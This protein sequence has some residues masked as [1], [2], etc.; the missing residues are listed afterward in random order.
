MQ[1]SKKLFCLIFVTFLINSNDIEEII[2]T[3][4]LLKDNENNFSPVQV[5]DENDFK[6]FN[7]TN[8][9]EISKYLNVSA[10]SRF[11][12]NALE[13]VDQGMS[14]ITLRGLDSSATL[15]LLNSKRHT[16]S[17]TP[18]NNGNGYIDA[19]IVPEIAIEKI[20]ILKEGATSIYGSDAI[21]GVINF[22]TFKDFEGLRIKVGEQTTTNYDQDDNSFG[23][24]YGTKILN[25]NLVIGFNVLERSPLSASEID[26]IAELGLSGLGK[27]FK[28]FGPDTVSSSL[29]AGVYP[30]ASQFVPDPNCEENGGVLD[31]SFCRFLYG[32]RFNIV[33]DESHQKIYLNFSKETESFKHN[34]HFISSKVDV[35][36]NPQ[37]PSYPALPFLSRN[38]EPGDGG[39]PFNVPVVWYGRPLGSEFKSPF[40]PKEIEQFNL[41]YS[42]SFLINQKTSAEISITKSEHSNEHFRPDIIDSRFLAAIKGNGGPDGNQTWNIF[43]SSQNPQSLID[44]VR[45]AEISSKLADLISIDGIFNTKIEGFNLAY[46]F[47]LNR[48][49]LD[50]FYDEI[51]RAEF[52]KDG[53]LIK[54]AD[55]FFLG[56]GKN[57]SKSRKSNALFAELEKDINEN[58]D[59]SL[60]ARF[61]SMKNESSF[62]PKVSLKYLV[63]DS[64]TIRFSKGTAFSAPSMAQMFS[65]EINLGSVRDIND[66]VF[67]RQASTGNPNLKPANST[68][69]NIGLIFQKNNL[70][71]SLDLWEI[72]YKDRVEVES[73]QAILSSNP[74]GP[75]VTRNEFGDLIGV[76][77]TYFN[78]DNTLVKGMDIQIQY[79][80]DL[81]K[82]NLSIDIMGTYLSDFKTPSL[83]NSNE[84]INRVGRFNFDN[85][86][87]SLPKKRIN[88]FI[89]WNF[90]DYSLSLNSRYLDGYVNERAVTGLG[91]TYGYNNQ[92][93]SFFVHDASFEKIIYM[94]KGDLNFRFYLSNIL[95]KSAPRL[96]DAPDFS[97]DTRLHDPRGRI[98]GLNIEY[99]Y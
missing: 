12:S 1:L 90:K 81:R 14:S 96:Y 27:T 21:A 57:L 78:E 30:K 15:L 51:S 44:Y 53:K 99:N 86:T 35:N 10:G 79:L 20:E 88:S 98:L 7:I 32:E 68:N 45:G 16:F 80:I 13:G 66:S 40:S 43:D 2:V 95:D 55:L 87:F 69:S 47:Q 67:V 41:N 63:S 71:L 23:L 61:E 59:I 31:G 91:L 25:G 94:S 93:K 92:V 65:S 73:A 18:S 54:T 37:S 64:L 3:G 11:Q 26:G 46:G 17:G 62:D 52:D 6:N 39:S 74:N 29:Y 97:F 82:G 19:N 58:L 75:S 38:I 42:L 89:S 72:K 33:N 22:F 77:T 84:M 9:G 83:T 60:A 8:I 34:L 28:V 70:R 48:E 76:T 50:I 56:G 4:T 85:H 36:D 49:N 24:L 5:I